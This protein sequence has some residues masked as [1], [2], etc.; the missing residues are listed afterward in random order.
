MAYLDE[1][2][3]RGLAK[4]FIKWYWSERLKAI[5]KTSWKSKN[6]EKIYTQYAK[7][8]QSL[9][10]NKFSNTKGRHAFFAFNFFDFVKYEA[11][12]YSE[13]LLIPFCEY[14]GLGIN[15]DDTQELTLGFYVSEH[16][17]KRIYQRSGLFFTGTGSEN[18]LAI[19]NEMR[20]LAIWANIWHTYYRLITIY[21]DKKKIPL[22]N[23]SL[24]NLRPII[25][26]ENGLFLCD[27]E[28]NTKLNLRNLLNYKMLI[29]VNSYIGS[30]DFKGEQLKY[31]DLLLQIANPFQNSISSFDN[32]Q[33][34][35][36][37]EKFQNQMKVESLYLVYKTY[38]FISN[39]LTYNGSDNSD[40]INF[41]N[42]F[43]S[44]FEK[45]FIISEVLNLDKKININYESFFRYITAKKYDVAKLLNI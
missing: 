20:L 3:S 25:P 32:L 35:V 10:I 34:N 37:P 42:F 27:F 16:A 45:S 4:Q 24:K 8:S 14:W 5:K 9:L 6:P 13:T 22:E 18:Y 36:F 21:L 38:P 30:G 15:D 12:S 44:L 31:R 23:S 39:L 28:F 41:K 7:S 33:S 17:I 43:D 26:S 19:V 1:S 11:T 29:R 40:N 2:I